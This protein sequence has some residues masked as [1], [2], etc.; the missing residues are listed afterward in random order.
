MIPGCAAPFRTTRSEYPQVPG[1]HDLIDA[2]G[3]IV[4]AIRPDAAQ[5]VARIL[6]AHG[7]LVAALQTLVS[8]GFADDELARRW[9]I[10]VERITAARAALAK[11]EDRTP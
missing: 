11:A 4:A 8:N 2:C 10:P 3:R 1:D 5:S 7:D 9:S 6:N